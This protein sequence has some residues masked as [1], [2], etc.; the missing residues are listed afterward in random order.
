M[1]Y[2]PHY[3]VAVTLLAAVMFRY[4]MTMASDK[5]LGFVLD[6]WTGDVIVIAGT[7]YT[8]VTKS[9]P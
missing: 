2:L 8:K 4:D 7:E 3:V 6:R 5:A 1:K 9:K